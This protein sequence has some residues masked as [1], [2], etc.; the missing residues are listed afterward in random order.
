VAC[1]GILGAVVG[2]WVTRIL[3]GLF[4]SA[5]GLGQDL[6]CWWYYLKVDAKSEVIDPENPDPKVEAA[7]HLS[8]TEL[9]QI[10][11]HHLIE[12]QETQHSGYNV[13]A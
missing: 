8:E 6:D 3:D 10:L 13:G 11:D 2:W 12:A 7:L 5:R 9:R 1:R 4:P